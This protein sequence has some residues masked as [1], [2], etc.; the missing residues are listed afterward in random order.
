MQETIKNRTLFPFFESTLSAIQASKL[1]A[2]MLGINGSPFHLSLTPQYGLKLFAG[3]KYCPECA[4][5]DMDNYGTT[6]WRIEHQI[7][8]VSACAIHHCNLL[9]VKNNDLC[10]DRRLSLPTLNNQSNKANFTDVIFS[11]YSKK[12]LSQYKSS[13]CEHESVEEIINNLK[14]L[15]FATPNGLLKYSQIVNELKFFWNGLNSNH[16]L[17]I[18]EPIQSFDFIGPMLRV[19]TRT[20]AHPMKYH[21]ILCWLDNLKKAPCEYPTKS[22][23][24]KH[25]CDIE[26]LKLAKAGKSMNLIEKELGVSRCYIRKLLEINGIYHKSNSMHL[27][28]KVIR[29]VV[30]KGLYGYTIE[31][32]SQQLALKTSTIEHIFCRTKG[33]SLWRKN[34]R[35]QKKLANAL[36]V[37]KSA[38]RKNPN[39][40]RK[41]IKEHHNAEFFSC[42]LSQ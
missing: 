34:L 39:W 13:K 14:A 29:K 20:P 37:I 18:P 25:N 27:S 28:E 11:R 9:G 10:L 16:P 2:A 24:V 31:D 17:G 42:L 40:L 19:K 35:H 26:I 8:G 33:L 22:K 30:I 4:R 3:H 23:N 32:I 21:L 41:D 1:K 5:R 7:P 38:V 15:G 36:A 6:I 12:K